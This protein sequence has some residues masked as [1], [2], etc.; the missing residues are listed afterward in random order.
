MLEKFGLLIEPSD[1][2]PKLLSKRVSVVNETELRQCTIKV[3]AQARIIQGLVH[4]LPRW[5]PITLDA[6]EF[7]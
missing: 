7:S 3:A 5:R 4:A 1:L 2:P 6:L